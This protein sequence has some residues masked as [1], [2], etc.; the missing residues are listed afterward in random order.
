MP[1]PSCVRATRTRTTRFWITLRFHPLETTRPPPAESRWPPSSPPAAPARRPPARRWSRSP[2]ACSAPKGRCCGASSRGS[3]ASIPTS[4]SSSAARPTPPTSATSSTSSG[5]TPGRATPTSSS[6][7][8]SGRPSSP[9]PGG[10]S[11]LD[12]FR[13][14]TA[15]FFPATIAANR[16]HG[17]LYAMPWFVDVGMLYWRTD[18][19][20][21]A[22]GHLRRAGP[23]QRARPAP[24]AP[25][26]TGLVWQGA[27][28]EGL[29]TV[30]LEYLG[31]FGGAIL[32][33]RPRRVARSAGRRGAHDLMR[34]QIYRTGVVPRSVADLARGGGALRLPERPGRVH[35]QLAVRL[36]A[37][38]GQRGLEGRGPLRRGADARG[39]GR[40]AHGGARR[41]PARD[42]RQHRAPGGG[43]GGDRVSD[44]AGA[45]AGA[46]PGGGPVPGAPHRRCT[47]SSSSPE[48]C[49]PAGPGPGRHRAR[50]AAAGHAG[51]H[52]AL[53]H[54][55][56]PAAP[57]AD[58][59]D[60]RRRPRC[61]SA[62]AV[63]CRRLL[64]R[65]GLGARRRRVPS[66]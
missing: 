53:R 4:G 3:C 34:D 61:A 35:A 59:A 37:A 56:D 65:V 12:R 11:P 50:G 27:R 32:D 13:P 54:P 6:S 28:Y 5:S 51:V 29:V 42:Q 21:S 7:T 18:L 26:G 15:A 10:S 9:P 40:L 64:D 66:R 22:A 16:W 1:V 47:T 23:H 25:C 24:R 38:A 33:G 39:P 52:P 14:D 62:A 17:R 45:D 20:P 2:A 44:S 46:R 57:R 19:M 49:D 36:R 63:R 30:F 43:L 55:P 48:R 60:W 31:A 58:P 41:G 8:R